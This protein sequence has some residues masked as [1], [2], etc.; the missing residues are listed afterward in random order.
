MCFRFRKVNDLNTRARAHRAYAVLLF[1][2]IAATA[3]LSLHQALRLVS[4]GS[5]HD[6][7]FNP[8]YQH[9]QRLQVATARAAMD[10]IGM[11][12]TDAAAA[13][14]RADYRRQRMQIQAD[15]EGLERWAANDRR[16]RGLLLE[17]RASVARLLIALDQASGAAS[18]NPGNVPLLPAL[19]RAQS[20]LNNYSASL[21][22]PGNLHTGQYL[23]AEPVLLWWLLILLLVEAAAL[24]WIAFSSY[25]ELL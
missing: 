10:V 7:V 2:A 17:T 13:D 23:F 9:S 12:G 22:E 19:N 15:S 3:W 4:S 24:A 20:S 6:V 25:K 14:Y 1:L 18:S 5:R 8:G 16:H 11:T 21:T